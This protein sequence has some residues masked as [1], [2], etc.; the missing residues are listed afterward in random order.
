[1]SYV[2][3]ELLDQTDRYLVGDQTDRD[4]E[5]WVIA[6]LQRILDSGDSAAINLANEV[7]VGFVELHEGI[8]GLSEFYANLERLVR[9]SRT[10]ELRHTEV[11][12]AV[13]DDV[14]SENDSLVLD[15]GDTFTAERDLQLTHSFA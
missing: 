14:G 3:I 1:M 11:A 15:V 10:H 2:L 13:R 12:N 9:A 6:N 8:V 4:L 5:A 7:D